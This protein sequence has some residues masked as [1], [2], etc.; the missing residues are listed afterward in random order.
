MW[1]R[2]ASPSAAI[3][4]QPLPGPLDQQEVARTA[5]DVLPPVRLDEVG[6]LLVQGWVERPRLPGHLQVP[7]QLPGLEDGPDC[8]RECGD[9]RPEVRVLLGGLQEVQ[10]LLA[11]EVVQ[12]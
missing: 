8:R 1:V 4:Q 5:A 11:D 6:V 12:G 2:S 10:E 9:R 7:G 3:T